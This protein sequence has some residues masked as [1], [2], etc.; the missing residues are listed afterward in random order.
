MFS[1]KKLHPWIGVGRLGL[2]VLLAVPASALGGDVTLESVG[3]RGGTS[4]NSSGQDFNQAEAAANWKLPW[5]WD[6]GR[7]FY[8]QSRL[9]ASAGW[10]GDRSVNAVIGT[11]GPTVLL[12]REHLPISLEGGCS[13]AFLTRSE[14]GSKN[15]GI[16]FQVTSHAGL[17]WDVTSHWRLGYRF[18]HMSNGGLSRNNPGLNLHMFG[19]SYLF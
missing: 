2:L 1:P 3:V 17:N 7:S 19:L 8:L 5:G 16:P 14:F 4:A 10:L 13:P 6:L 15:F 12:T 11:V 9:D 18:Q